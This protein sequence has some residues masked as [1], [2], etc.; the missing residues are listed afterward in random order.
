VPSCQA[1]PPGTARRTCYYEA[2]EDLHGV[3]EREK[4]IKA[5]SRRRKLELIREFNP[6]WRD[7]AGDLT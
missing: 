5:G 1:S 4:Q 3:I 2:G 7:L 6:E